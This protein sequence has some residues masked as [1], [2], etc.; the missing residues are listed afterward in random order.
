MSRIVFA[1][2]LGENHGHLWR[3]LPIARQL[4][5]RGHQVVFGLRSMTAAQRYLAPHGIGWFACP[6]PVGV[7]ELGRDI[8]TYADIL[9]INPSYAFEYLVYFLMVVAVGGLGSL[10]GPF[11]AA[12]L[13]GI[14]DTACKY[15]VPELGAFFIF[16]AM[17]A[18]L[19]WRPTGL[20]GR[21]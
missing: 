10:R 14:S 5:L 17:I 12:L 1:W 2:E 6:T 3:L 4:Q 7:A 21:A 19:L 9:A 11:V 15:L 18:I 13:L 8:A 16:V 20:F